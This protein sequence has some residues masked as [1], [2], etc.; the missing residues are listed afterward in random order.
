MPTD[1]HNTADRT[2][3]RNTVLAQLRAMQDVAY[4]R[5][6]DPDTS[7]AHAAQLM[8][9]HVDLERQRNAL[10]MRPAPKPMDPIEYAARVKRER[11]RGKAAPES[12]RK[13]RK[14]SPPVTLVKVLPPPDSDGCTPAQPS[15][16]R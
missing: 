2:P 3:H 5:A 7:A 6:I 10:R 14:P 13:S 8:R 11:E 12:A 16:N 4:K 1:P 9:A 15:D